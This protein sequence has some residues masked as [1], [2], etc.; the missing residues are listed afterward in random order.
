MVRAHIPLLT[1]PELPEDPADFLEYL[2]GL[3]LF[4]TASLSNE[5][6]ERTKQ[7]QT[8]AK[9][10]IEQQK[11]VDVDAFLESLDMVSVVEPFNQFNTP[12]V[13]QLTQR[14]NQFN[15]RTTRYISADIEKLAPSGDHYN[16]TFHT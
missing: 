1:I 6:A 16:F 3:N 9:R 15:L 11:H 12:R 4:E 13:A 10:H 5:D 7:Y 2:Y 14:S 8:A